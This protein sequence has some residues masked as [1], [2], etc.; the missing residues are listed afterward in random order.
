MVQA[1]MEAGCQWF[2][3]TRPSV[4]KLWQSVQQ[5]VWAARAVRV[6]CAIIATSAVRTLLCMHFCFASGC[7]LLARGG[8]FA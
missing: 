2:Y 6:V 8:A 3:E 4:V 7:V 1:L 5:G